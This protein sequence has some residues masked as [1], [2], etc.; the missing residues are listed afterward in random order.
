[1]KHN[2][3]NIS[4]V[5]HFAGTSEGAEEQDL[6]SGL[7]ILRCISNVNTHEIRINPHD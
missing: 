6:I 3:L 4:Y 1:M 2:K 7:R 5:M